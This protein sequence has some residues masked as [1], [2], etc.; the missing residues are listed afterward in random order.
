MTRTSMIGPVAAVGLAAAI[1]FSLVAGVAAQTTPSKAAGQ[2][3]LQAGPGPGFGPMA[4][5]GL[6]LT[7]E[8]ETK[9]VALRT[10][11]QP[12]SQAA[13]DR[14]SA[15]R[16]KLR[17]VEQASTLDEKA[18]REAAVAAANA[19][20]DMA[21]MRAKHRTQFLALLTPEQRTKAEQRFA[22]AQQMGG[23]GRADRGDQQGWQQG[24]QGHM[25]RQGRMGRNRGMRMM[26]PCM[27]Q[28][29]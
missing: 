16:Q 11:Q 25:G 6:G 27:E 8:Q 3:S 9:V 22:M 15:A 18:L 7:P 21:V 20:A 19:Q 12:E 29:Y 26:C 23:R 5:R 24:R 10:Q 14:L 4:A 28:Q 2:P 17:D 1:A 13:R